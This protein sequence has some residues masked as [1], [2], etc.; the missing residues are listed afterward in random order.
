MAA[1]TILVV[2]DETDILDLVAFNLE[3]AGYRVLKATDG[4]EA[5]RLTREE[6]PDLMVLDL[7]LPHLEGKEVCRRLRQAEETRDLPV[8]MLTARAE[9]TDRIVGFEIGAD[10]YLTKPFSPQE[11]VLRVKAVLRRTQAPPAEEK[12]LR[13]PG[14]VLDQERHRVE[15]EGREIELTATEFRLLFHLAA[16]PGR[17]QTR[18]VLL[19]RVWGYTFEG[20]SRTVDTHIRRLRQKL[21][22]LRDLIQTVRGVGYRFRE[23]G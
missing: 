17:V 10:D 8:I 19:D 2:E 13:F 23:Q 7:M 14:L 9:E 21:G 11:L 22:P 16:N 15:V 12:L 18:E 20:Y 3:Q 6:H 1:Q 4:L 5:L